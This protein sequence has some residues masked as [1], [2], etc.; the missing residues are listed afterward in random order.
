MSHHLEIKQKMNFVPFS[1]TQLL[2]PKI[3][4]SCISFL[5]SL[6]LQVITWE[7]SLFLTQ[8]ECAVCVLYLGFLF[9]F[10]FTVI[11][12][13][14]GLNCARLDCFQCFCYCI[15]EHWSFKKWECLLAYL[16]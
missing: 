4:I 10:N 6:C 13:K 16:G 3:P 12:F 1:P 5:D 7:I 9:V 2:S 11:Y 8:M 14:R 15:K